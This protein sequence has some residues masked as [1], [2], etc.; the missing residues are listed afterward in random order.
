MM[1]K[2]M[3]RCKQFLNRL[4]LRTLK[5]DILTLF[6]SLT[7]ITFTFVICYSYFKNYHAILK[8]S[9]GTMERNSLALIERVTHIQDEAEQMLH[10]TAGLL[11]G[12]KNLYLDDP[13]LQLFMLSL[14]KFN[15]DV[16]S[17]F[18]AFPSGNRLLVKKIESS[19]Q[20]YFMTKPSQ[21]L[22]ANA[23]YIIKTM[24]LTK[25]PYPETWYYA[26][27][28]FNILAKEDFP[29]ITIDILTRPWYQG[30]VAT[31]QVYWTDPYFFLHTHDLGI[32][33]SSPVFHK[34]S[35]LLA[36][37]G[38]DISFIELSN[39]LKKQTIGQFGHAFL[40]NEK[41][42]LLVPE[43][44]NPNGIK[45]P[46]Q[47]L[48]IAVDHF[49]KTSER[50]FSFT[51]DH[52]RYL[53][54]VS[55][56]PTIFGKHWLI[57]TIVPFSDFFADLIKTQFEVILIT[58]I[59]LL[60]S[61]LIIIYFSKR[62][63]KPIVKLAKEVDK[64]TNLDLSSEKRIHSHIIEIRMMDNSVASLRAAL[65]SFSRYVPKEIVKQLLAQG[66]E[67]TLHMDKRKLTILFSDIQDF[68]TIAETN[69][70]NV[71]MPLLNEY[72]DGLSKIILENQ[73]TIDKYIGDSI[74][75]FWGAPSVTTDHAVLACKTA[76]LCQNFLIEF[77]RNCREQG[78]PEL[79][80]RIGISSG[81]VVVGNIGT[82]ERMNYTVIGD[83]VNA[84]ARLQV[85]DKIYHVHIIISD[86]V[87]R[88][89]DNRFL[90]RP[91]DKVEVRGK[92]AKIKIYELVAVN[93]PDSPISATPKQRELCETF[94]KAYDAYAQGDFPTAK[95]LFE[96]IHQK[97]PNDFP[98][99]FY[100]N[101][102][103]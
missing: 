66:K 35:T 15:P 86:E 59:I 76:L 62:I 65:R 84:A 75:A 102:L 45:I 93:N 14:L 52:T 72:F 56:F 70:L 82:L 61:I 99:Q 4:W 83:A 46:P 20:T 38:V 22:P 19:T 27:S 50:N 23:V 68:T 85:T 54:F 44:S 77:N 17:F 87:Y 30:A 69:S 91:L 96:A 43:F 24:D 78:K 58:L 81:A 13:E 63:S 71:L 88:Q 55:N 8:Y 74:M 34:D 101:R 53:C 33:A 31:K 10:S 36:I 6:I 28:T 48:N 32:T 73:G 29:K 16:S 25:T 9:K 37:L 21:P 18:I 90:V 95:Q 89:T 67:I 7:I 11:I 40:T 51:M 103:R 3:L 97:F 49:K 42:E 26:D 64:I 79:I 39:F 5:I 12:D 98:T 2:N 47:A 80:T 57:I 41:G 1:G 100:L 92:K 94:T 60:L